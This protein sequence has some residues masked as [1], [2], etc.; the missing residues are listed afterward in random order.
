MTYSATAYRL[1]ISGPADVRDEDRFAVTDAVNRW[2][3][4][5]GRQFGRV[6]VP[7]HWRSHSAAMHG[8]RPQATLNAQLVESADIVIALF[9]HRLGS[10]TGEDRSGTVEEINEANRRGAYV[11]VLRCTRA[12]PT[13]VDPPQL[14]DLRAYLDEIQRE[15]LMLEYADEGELARHVE[16]ILIAAVTRDGARAEAA[17]E[18]AASGA[19]VWPRVE[20]SE[21]VNADSA[22]HLTT[23]RHWRLVLANAG[24][25]PARDVRF[26]LESEDETHRDRLPRLYEDARPI[27]ALAPGTE[28]PYG[29]SVYTGVASQVR[30]VVTWEDSHGRR[31]NVATLRFF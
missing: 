24:T 13:N 1:L 22:G 11:A 15:S 31:E 29:V 6:V 9:W 10:P 5:Y 17:V 8:H 30:C 12:L 2:N 19:Q 7:T 21:R 25:E 27:D 16:A 14:A 18:Y 26:H 23:A 20:S 4:L 3:A 28:A